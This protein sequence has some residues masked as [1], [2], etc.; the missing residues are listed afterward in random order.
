MW[1]KSR[2]ICQSKPSRHWIFSAPCHFH[3]SEDLQYLTVSGPH[4]HMSGVKFPQA[5]SIWDCNALV[6]EK[7]LPVSS[8]AVSLAMNMTDQWV[9]SLYEYLSHPQSSCENYKPWNKI[10]QHIIFATV[11]FAIVKGVFKI[12]FPVHV[13]QQLT[14]RALFYRP[15]LQI[16]ALHPGGSIPNLHHRMSETLCSIHHASNALC[17]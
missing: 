11:A 15:L 4:S 6:M 9:L 12:C 16:T 14:S 2:N 13:S 7:L 1:R 3:R 5:P 17:S 8:L 10:N